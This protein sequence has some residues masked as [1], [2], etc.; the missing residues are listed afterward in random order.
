MARAKETPDEVRHWLNMKTY[1]G[2]AGV[3]RFGMVWGVGA[4]V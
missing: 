3:H 2:L 1:K 4:K